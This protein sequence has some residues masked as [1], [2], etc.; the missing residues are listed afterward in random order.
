VNVKKERTSQYSVFEDRMSAEYP[1]STLMIVDIMLTELCNRTC[2]FCPRAVDYPNLNLHMDLNLFSKICD[3]LSDI[4]YQN[5]VLLCGFGE[6]L[7]YK[8]IFEAIQIL[9]SKLPHNEYLQIVTNGDRLTKDTILKLYESGLNRIYV[10]CYDGIEQVDHFQSMFDELN[11]DNNNYYFMHYYKPPEE[12]YGFVHYSNR[13][14]KLFN[15]TSYLN[16]GCNSPSYAMQINWDGKV[17]LCSHDWTKSVICGDLNNQHLKNIW[18]YS[19]KYQQYRAMLY[20]NKRDTGP[21]NKC[22]VVGTLYG[23]KSKQLLHNG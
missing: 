2:D 9:R 8:N 10:S 22:N 20:K 19:P 13:G 3:D 23:D 14:G 7:L 16:R 17:L 21:C 18:L 11:I 4:Y 5:R 15:D 12:N 1:T 6:N